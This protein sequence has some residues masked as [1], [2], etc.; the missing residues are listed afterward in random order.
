MEEVRD[1]ELIDFVRHYRGRKKQYESRETI[2]MALIGKFYGRISAEDVWD[3]LGRCRD[4]GIISFVAN[5]N[6]RFR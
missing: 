3:V 1:Y 6:I 4:L 2:S 5:G